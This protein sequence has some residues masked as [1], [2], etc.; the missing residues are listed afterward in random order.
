MPAI[1]QTAIDVHAYQPR[2]RANGPGTRF[3]LWFQG[4]SLGCPGCFNPDTH[5]AGPRRR[6]AVAELI[7]LFAGQG[8][9]IEGI[10]LSGGEPLEQPDAMLALV[11]EVRA[12]TNLSIVVFSGYTIDEIRA[13]P[14]GGEILQR[15][16]V[17]IDGRYQAARRIGRGL[18]GS[19][20]QHIHLLTGRYS[21]SEVEATPEAEIRIDPQGRVTLTGVAPLRLKR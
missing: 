3:V 12:H 20:N 5:P 1:G 18:R 6:L 16:D 10:T 14:S 21:M 9:T 4:C 8:D 19:S 17:L 11:S 7:A 13:M 15:I 2:S